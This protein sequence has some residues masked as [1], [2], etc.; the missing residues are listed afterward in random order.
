MD[1][2]NSSPEIKTGGAE[3]LP[4][5]KHMIIY[6]IVHMIVYFTTNRVSFL[7]Y[8]HD[9]VCRLDEILPVVKLFILPYCI[10][11]PYMALTAL[12]L[13]KKDMNKLK[14]LVKSIMISTIPVYLV[15]I[16]FPTTMPLRPDHIDGNDILTLLLNLIYFFDNSANVF[17]SLHVLWTLMA[18]TAHVN[19]GVSKRPVLLISDIVIAVLICLSTFMIKQHSALDVIGALPFYLLGWYFT[20]GKGSGADVSTAS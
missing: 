7:G 14:R 10:W 2:N 3:R 18:L 19:D 16:F 20:Y 6:L 15:F 4:S 13:L 9:V 1:K 5:V 11:F 12:Y 17:P 8:R